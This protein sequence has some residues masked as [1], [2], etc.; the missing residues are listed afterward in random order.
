[1]L[2][3]PSLTSL[4]EMAAEEVLDGCDWNLIP[5]IALSDLAET[6][7]MHLAMNMIMNKTANV[8]RRM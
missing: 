7:P 1:M 6:N 2:L 8:L 3:S 5:M 4:F